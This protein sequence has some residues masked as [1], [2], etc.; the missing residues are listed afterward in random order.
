MISI[1]T[2]LPRE[3]C[4]HIRSLRQIPKW[5]IVE[6]APVMA[7]VWKYTATRNFARRRIFD[8]RLGLTLKHHGVREFA[9]ANVKDF[10]EIG[11][12]KVWNPLA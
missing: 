12:L 2:N 3:A 8:I 4:D 5:R 9:T 10:K 1:D 7:E 11:F 6:H